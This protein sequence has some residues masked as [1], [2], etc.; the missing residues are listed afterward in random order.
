MLHPF[1]N[2]KKKKKKH[3]N[4]SSEMN[5]LNKVLWQNDTPDLHLGNAFQ[6]SSCMMRASA[7]AKVV[8]QVGT[9]L[10]QNCKSINIIRISSSPQ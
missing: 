9:L 8:S 7:G 2:Y 1:A 6:A 10:Q 5:M 3:V 4:V